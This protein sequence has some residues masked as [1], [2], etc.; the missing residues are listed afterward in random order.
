[1]KIQNYIPLKIRDVSIRVVHL[2][3]VTR[4]MIKSLQ[5]SYN[6]D[7][8]SQILFKVKALPRHDSI[9]LQLK[10]MSY[11]NDVCLKIVMYIY[12]YIHKYI[13]IYIYITSLL[14][15]LFRC[16]RQNRKVIFL[17]KYQNQYE[18]IQQRKREVLDLWYSSYLT[19]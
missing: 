15:L 4:K 9:L 17:R 7:L 14:W 10:Y 18:Q 19:C 11:N 3:H 12:T 16:R 8:I 2:I 13:Y 6:K 1:M 5:C